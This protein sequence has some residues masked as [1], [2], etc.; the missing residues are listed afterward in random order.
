[1]SAHYSKPLTRLGKCDSNVMKETTNI[2]S[3]Q[4]GDGVHLNAAGDEL[5]AQLVFGALDRI[6]EKSHHKAI[7]SDA[8]SSRCGW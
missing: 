8:R 5:L 6:I 2:E 7:T 3:L 4:V 1:M